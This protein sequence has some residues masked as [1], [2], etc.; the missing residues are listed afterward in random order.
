MFYT[1]DKSSVR[2]IKPIIQQ[3]QKTQPIYQEDDEENLCCWSKGE[4]LAGKFCQDSSLHGLKY[5]GQSKRHPSERLF[6]LAAFLISGVG[7]FITIL[8]LWEKYWES[9]VVT[10][11]QPVETPVDLI[12]FPAVT[13]CNV[14][15]VRR[16]RANQYIE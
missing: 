5:I 12:P 4:S 13:I 8:T 15:N 7:C 11:F 2:E 14:N 10:V 6:W 9:P 16:S 1:F 3:I